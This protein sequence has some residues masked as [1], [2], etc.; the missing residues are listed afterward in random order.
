MGLPGQSV[1][2]V[3][4]SVDF[5]HECGARVQIE[6][7]SLI[8]GTTEWERADLG[9]HLEGNVDPLLH[10]DSIYPFSWYEASLDDFRRVKARATAGNRALA[11]DS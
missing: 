6:A 7:I 9:G 4:D 2:G 11:A 10:N 1:Q 8:P 5:A 3:V